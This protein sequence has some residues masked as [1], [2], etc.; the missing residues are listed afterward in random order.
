MKLGCG[1]LSVLGNASVT[2]SCQLDNVTDNF[3]PGHTQLLTFI[4]CISLRF[5]RMLTGLHGKGES[6]RF[7]PSTTQKE[8]SCVSCRCC[9]VRVLS[10]TNADGTTSIQMTRLPVR[11]RS[12]PTL[13]G[14]S[15]KVEHVF[16]HQLCRQRRDFFELWS[17]SK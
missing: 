1:W 10:L 8:L 15:S 6:Q 13:W 12:A 3:G 16:H 17:E 2:T 14:G 11:V 5:A 4:S 9:R 7:E